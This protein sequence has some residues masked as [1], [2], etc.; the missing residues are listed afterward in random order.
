MRIKK[1]IFLILFSCCGIYAEESLI[2]LEHV[3]VSENDRASILR[4]AKIFAGTCMVCHTAKYLG[5]NKLA[6]ESGITL[7]KMPLNNKEWLLNVVPPDLSLEARQRGADWIYTYIHAFYKDPAQPTGF[8][9]LLVPN[10][11]MT[12]IFAA[13]QGVQEREIDRNIVTPIFGNKKPHYYQVLKLVQVGSQSPEEFDETTRDIVNFLVY[14]S[15]PHASERKSLGVYVL[16][17]L[18]LFFV[19]VFLLKKL[20]WK[21]IK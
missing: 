19:V 14:A 11:V 9:N 16:L 2:Q 1:F 4:G 10:T 7:S 12:N 5:N 17:F 8:N 21:R 6:N 15:D 13:Q 3:T 18:A 20:V